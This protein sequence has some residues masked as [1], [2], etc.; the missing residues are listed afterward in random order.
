MIESNNHTRHETNLFLNPGET[1]TY[2]SDIPCPS[3]PYVVKAVTERG[4][5]A[6]C[7]GT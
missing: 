1:I 7:S 6:V 5:L 3:E 4:N 2:W